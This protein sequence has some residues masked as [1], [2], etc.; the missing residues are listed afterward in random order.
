VP[1]ALVPP[2]VVTVISIVPAVPAGLVA[3]IWVALFTVKVA[4]LVVPNL[5]AVAFVRFV[6]VIVTTVPPVVVPLVGVIPVTVGGAT[7]VNPSAGPVALV[8]PTVVTVRSTVPAVPAGAVAV[9][10]VALFTVKVAALVVPNLTAVAFVRFVPVI[11]TTVPPV[12]VPLVTLIPVTVGG[13][14]YVN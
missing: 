2:T 1:T 9:I 12:V 11:V 14:T 13:A 7:Y 6:P 5:T 4:A 8:P 3:V 10:W